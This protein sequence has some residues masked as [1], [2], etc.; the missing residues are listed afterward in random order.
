MATSKISVIITNDGINALINAAHTGS[1]KV[2]LNNIKFFSSYQA[3]TVNTHASDM[4]ASAKVADLSA[5]GGE[6]TSSNTLH[7]D[8]A[9]NSDVAYKA[10]TIGIYT[11]DG[12]LFGATSAET[13]ILEKVETSIAMFACDVLIAN[14][15]LSVVE[16]DNPVFTNPTATTTKAGVVRLATDDEAT[17]MQS[18][19]IAVTPVNL[20][21]YG[22]Y[23]SKNG[24][25]LS[26]TKLQT[27]RTIALSGG[28]TGTATSFNG[29][30]NITIPVTAVDGSKVTGTVPAATKATQDGSGNTIT[31]KY[32]TLDTTQTISGTKTFSAVTK[33]ATPSAS[34]TGTEVV[35]AAWVRS[36]TAGEWAD[37]ARRH[38]NIYRGANLLSGHF[39][40]LSAILTAIAAKNFEDI[41]I[42]DYF[43]A[44]FI[45]DGTT[46]NPKW[47][48]AGIMFYD[49]NAGD[50][51]GYHNGHV[52]IVPDST[53]SACMNDTNTTAGGYVGSKMYTTTLPK[54]YTALAGTSGTPFYGHIRGRTERLSTTVDTSKPPRSQPT[55]SGCVSSWSDYTDQKLTL[56]SEVEMWGH[57]QWSSSGGEEEMGQIQLPLFRLCPEACGGYKA[58]NT[59]LRSVANDTFFCIAGTDLGA[60]AN[61]ASNVVAVRPR[62]I[63]C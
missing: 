41:Y 27:A 38:N 34:A 54:L 16:F 42:G 50:A 25:A 57:P 51:W 35:T 28:A 40:N 6:Q 43:N 21:A 11:S 31:S 58:V 33:S 9:D 24:N 61:L 46:Y 30:A 23:L 44:S 3:V 36:N 59:W 14:A 8:C 19:T 47:R 63:L 45:Y 60:G 49:D 4:P 10:Y 7:I 55:W 20:K 12:I 26:A 39:S 5:V 1:E 17:A 53:I 62:F 13:P 52:V 29:T 37:T 2:T 48:V 18:S 56:L 32:V 15:D 22:D